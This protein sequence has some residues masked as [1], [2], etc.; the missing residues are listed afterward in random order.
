M[1]FLHNAD[2]LCIV[3]KAV[4]THKMMSTL[5]EMEIIKCYY[6]VAN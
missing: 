2:H 3:S 1:I 6:E 4:N 5:H